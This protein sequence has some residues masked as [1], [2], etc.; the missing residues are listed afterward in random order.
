M[1]C[2]IVLLYDVPFARNYIQIPVKCQFQPQ[3]ITRAKFGKHII[4]IIIMGDE[5]QNNDDYT[6]V[7]PCIF[8]RGVH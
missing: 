7:S 8:V 6:I 3:M 4:T 5:P 1:C 2:T